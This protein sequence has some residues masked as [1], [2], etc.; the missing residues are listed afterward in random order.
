MIPKNLIV[1]SSA[2]RRR[3]GIIGLD[4]SHGVS[5]AKMLNAEDADH[6]FLGYK[7]VAAYPKGTERIEAIAARIEGYTREIQN[8]GVE[9]VSSIQ[10]LLS[11]VDAV[12]VMT[13]DGT[14][15]LEQTLEVIKAKKPVFLNKPAAAVLKDV[16]VIY[17]EAAKN[18]VPIFSSSSLRFF[19]RE[20]LK[21]ENIGKVM[22]VQ[23]YSPALLEPSHTDL[24]WYGIHG[25]EI[26]YTVLGK[27]CQTLSRVHTPDSDIV[28]GVWGDGTVGV[29][30]GIRSGRRG[31]GGTVFGEKK[32]AEI[33]R[34]KQAN[35]D[36]LATIAIFFET[37]QSPVDVQDTIEIYAFMAA[38]D[39]SKNNG[40]TSVNVQN[41]IHS[42]KETL[43]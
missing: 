14:I 29:F 16:M 13:N 42:I 17:H 27:G 39:E 8:Y 37:G 2:Q 33:V 15:R 7:V 4:I 24:F 20:I 19:D 35:E 11:K 32:I 9:I 18:R 36:M 41:I 23:T 3:V 22:G 34:S 43:K 38:A 5:L 26:L 28:T 40:G 1:P 12:M 21:E 10:E 31:Y 6:R 30:R 25:V